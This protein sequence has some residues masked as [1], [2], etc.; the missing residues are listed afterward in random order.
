[1]IVEVM[2]KNEIAQGKNK[3]GKGP[4]IEVSLSIFSTYL[5]TASEKN[6]FSFYGV[7]SF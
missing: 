4:L 6:V 5:L 1:M 7:F 3:N 2:V